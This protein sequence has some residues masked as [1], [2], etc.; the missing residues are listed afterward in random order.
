LECSADVAT[1]ILLTTEI[2]SATLD[3]RSTNELVAEFSQIS[4]RMLD[5][6][7]SAELGNI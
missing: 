5:R 4:S 7:Q 3:G 2:D 1:V 6:A